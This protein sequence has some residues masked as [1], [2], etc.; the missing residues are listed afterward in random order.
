MGVEQGD[1][2]VLP[3]AGEHLLQP[4]DL[5]PGGLDGGFAVLV[6]HI[7]RHDGIHGKKLFRGAHI[8]NGGS[9]AG[10]QGQGQGEEKRKKAFHGILLF[11][12]REQGKFIQP[13]LT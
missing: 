8:P 13:I 6:Q 3:G 12:P 10:G 2:A 7:D 11:Y 5:G 4:V 9:A 1:H